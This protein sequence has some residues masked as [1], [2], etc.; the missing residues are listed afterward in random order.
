VRRRRQSLEILW[1]GSKVKPRRSFA[2]RTASGFDSLV[3]HPSLAR[4]VP[5]LLDALVK[6]KA[7]LGRRCSCLEQ[8]DVLDEARARDQELRP[9]PEVEGALRGVVPERRAADRWLD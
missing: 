7:R 6:E 1:R 3:H 5:P 2:H 9:Q 4:Q 8:N